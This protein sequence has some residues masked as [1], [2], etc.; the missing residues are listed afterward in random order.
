VELGVG[1]RAVLL[2]HGDEGATGL[3]ASLRRAIH[4][5]EPEQPV[6]SVTPLGTLVAESVGPQRFRA[7]LLGAFAAMAVVLA[8][9]GIYGVVGQILAGRTHELGIRRA[10]GASGAD[11]AREVLRWG[12]GLATLGVGAGLAGVLALGGLVDALLYGVGAAD[13]ATLAAA[14][15]LVLALTLVACAVPARRAARIDPSEAL[16]P[17]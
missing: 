7:L 14:T 8:V 13:P 4:E 2:V 16:R 1:R 12:L 15:L 3:A 17:D 10:V 5:V 11:V 9:A 6:P